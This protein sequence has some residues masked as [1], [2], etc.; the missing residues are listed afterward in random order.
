MLETLLKPS[1]LAELWGISP[2]TV[3]GLVRNEGLPHVPVGGLR[4]LPSSCQ[5]WLEERQRGGPGG[6]GGRSASGETRRT[7]PSE[8]CGTEDELTAEGLKALLR[9]AA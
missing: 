9:A 3:Y 4:F 5:R 7:R 1:E 6:S 8:T 2:S